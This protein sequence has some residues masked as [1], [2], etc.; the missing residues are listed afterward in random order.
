MIWVEPGTFTMGSPETEVGRNANIEVQ[1]EV[2]FTNGFYLGKYEVTQA[3]Y[4]AVMTGNDYG[5]SATPSEWPNH[6][7]SPVEKVSWDDIQLFLTH[8]NTQHADN[9]PTGWAYVLPTEAEWEYACR[10]G[11]STVY[12]WGGSISSDH[13]NYG[14]D[15]DWSTEGGNKKTR[16]VGQY[17]ANLWGF[18]DMHGNVWEWTADRFGLYPTGE[19]IDPEGSE[20]G[21]GRTMRGGSWLSSG[22][23][24]RSAFRGSS[25][26]R[27]SYNGADS[28]GFRLA[29]QQ[30]TQQE[31]DL[32]ATAQN[33]YAYE[34]KPSGTA[35][36]V[37]VTDAPDR[38]VSNKYSLNSNYPDE[39]NFSIRGNILYSADVFDASIQQDFEIGI[40]IESPDGY[41]T[42]T[43]TINIRVAK[44]Y[45]GQSLVLNLYGKDLRGANMRG[46]TL[47]P[48]SRSYGANYSDADLTDANF[49]GA[50]LESAKFTGANLSGTILTGAWFN[51]A[52]V[53][54]GRF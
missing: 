16:D 32:N 39:S 44:D 25:L 48:G 4:E 2:S 33:L 3:Q 23:F 18:Y 53:L 20:T 38:G 15:G 31:I 52:T 13:A 50:E 24:L 45:S 5:L 17:T 9:I 34:Q 1:Y 51:Q 26:P 36:G 19:Q 28:F 40:D 54:A 42:T 47:L 11:T 6:P 30:V 37:F 29:F 43:H 22:D 10:A 12:S 14:W 35:I 41:V 7:N 46:F 27:N 8:L 21:N 49:S